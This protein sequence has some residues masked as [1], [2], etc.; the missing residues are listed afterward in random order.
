MTSRTSTAKGSIVPT[1]RGALAG[2]HKCRQ[3]IGLRHALNRWRS[4]RSCRDSR[5]RAENGRLA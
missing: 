2:R 4:A 1:A 3:T 5:A